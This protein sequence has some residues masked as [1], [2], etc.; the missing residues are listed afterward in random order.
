MRSKLEKTAHNT[1]SVLCQRGHK[2]F[3][4][5]MPR[6]IDGAVI[7]SRNRDV[8]TGSLPLNDLIE[9]ASSPFKPNRSWK[10]SWFDS[11]SCTSTATTENL[12]IL[13]T[14]QGLFLEEFRRNHFLST[15]IY[16]QELTLTANTW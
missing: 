10:S 15:K 7:V 11:R 8:Q 12:K 2:D 9:T 14:V 1:V 5:N 4:Q 6:P 13:P 3:R 16:I